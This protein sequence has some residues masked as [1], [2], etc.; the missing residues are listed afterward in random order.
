MPDC[1]GG[2]EGDKSLHLAV[3]HSTAGK[4]HR[5][6]NA[7]SF[8]AGLA[9]YYG[10]QLVPVIEEGEGGT[11]L[12]QTW[13]YKSAVLFAR[14]PDG[15]FYTPADRA[16]PTPIKTD[17]SSPS[18]FDEAIHDAVSGISNREAN[19]CTKKIDANA[20][21]DLLAISKFEEGL[22]TERPWQG[23]PRKD[24]AA[25]ST[26][27]TGG[28]L[29]WRVPS[30]WLNAG[31]KQVK[32]WILRYRGTNEVQSPSP[33]DFSFCISPQWKEFYLRV[34]SPERCQEPELIHVFV[35]D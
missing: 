6:R 34:F 25:E 24:N 26:L 29:I 13:L 9:T 4:C 2:N 7:C 22:G 17:G 27:E 8:G 5:G 21:S 16:M 33:V 14:R 3:N 20:C 30:D 31:K 15:S 35:S 10:V 12:T 32:N 23:Y 11:V 18:D 28:K 1:P 19:S